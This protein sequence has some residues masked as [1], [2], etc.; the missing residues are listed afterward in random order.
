MSVSFPSEPERTLDYYRALFEQA[1]DALL[2]VALGKDGELLRIV[3]GNQRCL[4]CLGFARGELL[5]ASPGSV[6]GRQLAQLFEPGVEPRV[7]TLTLESKTGERILGE[8]RTERLTL[9]GRALALVSFRAATPAARSEREEEQVHCA[10]K[11]EAIGELAGG[12]A[13][14]FNNLL[15]VVLRYSSLVLEGIRPEDPMYVDVAEIEKAGKRAA[16]L[17]RQLLAFSRR[18]PVETGADRLG[19]PR[20]RARAHARANLG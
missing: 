18:S 12:I 2:V 9:D 17:T 1:S 5:D 6:L 10:Q 13:H 11:L 15:T 3:D 8:A 16:A 20:A 4:E 19:R 14:D 7:R